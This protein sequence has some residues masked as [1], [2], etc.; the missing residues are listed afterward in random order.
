MRWFWILGL[1]AGVGCVQIGADDGAYT[2]GDC[3]SI[4]PDEPFRAPGGA[5]DPGDPSVGAH[6]IHLLGGTKSVGSPCVACHPEPD[7]RDLAA[8]IDGI[9]QIEWGSTADTAGASLDYDGSGSCTVWCHGAALVGGTVA[10]PQW[11]RVDGSQI[12]CGSCHGLPPGGLHTE[13]PACETCHDRSIARDANDLPQVIAPELHMN[14]VFNV[15]EEVID[16]GS[17]DY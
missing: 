1:W 4:D 17:I 7:P 15:H 2:C 3:H 14:G 10:R 8:H 12:V 5:T 16:P 13:D 6:P 9:A 11:T